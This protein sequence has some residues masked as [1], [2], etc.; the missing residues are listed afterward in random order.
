MSYIK[1]EEIL[2][3]ELIRQIQEYADGVYIYIPRKPGTRHAWGQETD[4][5]AE[6]KLRNDRIRS[7]YA[8]GTNV[9]ALSRKYHLSE[10]SIRRILQNQ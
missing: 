4:Y 5:K 10:K 9:V 7:D 2:P 1:A 8:A 3:E 6:L